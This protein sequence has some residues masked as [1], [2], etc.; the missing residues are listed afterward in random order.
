MDERLIMS[1]Q[2]NTADDPESLAERRKRNRVGKLH[3]HAFMARDLEQ[4][5]HFYE[6]IL[7]LPF[8]G[9]WVERVN[10]TTN[11]PDNY[12]HVFFELNDGS[13]LAFFQFKDPAS[14]LEHSINKFGRVSP[15]GH[16]I[17]LTV[18][19]KDA[20]LDLKRRL[21]EAEIETFLTD[22]GYVYS[23]YFH[24]P[25]GLQVELTTTVDASDEMMSEAVSTAHAT[26]ERW[27]GEDNTES[28]NTRRGQG[29]MRD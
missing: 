14:S 8:V 16:H 27:R 1:V 25:N 23:V 2:Q 19:G 10:P 3:H 15:F 11:Q 5:R 20:V 9:T 22:H 29:W 13:C 6:D 7:G 17:A 26:L 28:N 21:D 24:D 12:A 4:T 18:D